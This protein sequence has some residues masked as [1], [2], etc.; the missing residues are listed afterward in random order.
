MAP[1]PWTNVSPTAASSHQMPPA[2]RDNGSSCRPRNRNREPI[3]LWYVFHT[4]L[5]GRVAAPTAK[6]TRNTG[7]SPSVGPIAIYI[8]GVLSSAV[9]SRAAAQNQHRADQDAKQESYFHSIFSLSN[10]G[11]EARFSTYHLSVNFS[12]SKL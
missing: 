6:T 12:K 1:I 4:G 7:D 9:L 5:V 3:C 10:S 2:Q 8:S 11:P